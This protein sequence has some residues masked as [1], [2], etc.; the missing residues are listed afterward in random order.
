MLRLNIKIIHKSIYLLVLL[1]IFATQGQTALA[2]AGGEMKNKVSTSF[3]IGVYF[4]RGQKPIADNGGE[5]DFRSDPEQA[6]LEYSREFADLASEGFNTA[7][8][9]VD[10]LAYGDSFEGVI[11]AILEEAENNGI[12]L[13]IPLLHVQALLSQTQGEI[14]NSEIA[15]AACQDYLYL[16]NNSKAVMAYVIFD[17]PAP[18]GEP[19]PGGQSAYPEQLGKVR[20]Y[21]ESKD[22]GVY[23]LSTWADVS[24]MTALQAGMH[25]RVLF[26]DLYPLAEDKEIGD[27]S[28][29]WPRGNLDDG[30]FALGQDQPTYSEYLDLAREA[31]PGVPQWLIIQAFEPIPPEHPHYWRIPTPTEMRL[32]IFSALAHGAQGIFYFLYQSES[33]V[34]GLRDENYE[35][36][37]LLEEAVFINE[38]IQSMAELLL[39]LEREDLVG[40]EPSVGEAFAFID[41]NK[42]HYIFIVN[43]DVSQ[44]STIELLLPA[45]WQEASGLVDVYDK[46]VF[47]LNSNIL[48]ITVQPGDGR[49]LKAG[50]VAE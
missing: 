20:E 27:F 16:F 49:L 43:T 10:P 7:V 2:Q 44:A 9:S 36:T 18:V 17:E 11:Q 40:L 15:Q 6:R 23:A 5:V 12:S 1:F 4:V 25:S 45:D 21:I 13:I 31:V 46:N 3:P 24:S 28:D 26:M 37:A 19:A 41:K 35:R 50:D 39:D 14:S 38:K 29:A 47:E 42:T 34:H 8:L 33:W 22:P 30:S 48:K 32:E